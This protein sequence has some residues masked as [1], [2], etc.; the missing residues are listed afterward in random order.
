MA[1]KVPVDA[2]IGTQRA[3]DEANRDIRDL[4]RKLSQISLESLEK[5][6]ENLERSVSELQHLRRIPAYGQRAFPGVGPLFLDDRLNWSSPFFSVSAASVSATG[7]VSGSGF[8]LM[9]DA[10]GGAVTVQLPAVASSFGR[11]LIIKKTDASVNAVTVDPNGAETIDGA[12]SFSLPTQHDVVV[13][14]CF[15]TEWKILATY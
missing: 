13:I 11:L 10:S 14:V 12:A 4:D 5:D 3:F 6:V 15:T 7:P 8:I 1:I 2:T 9:V